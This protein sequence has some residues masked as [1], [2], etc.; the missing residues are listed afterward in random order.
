M[1]PFQLHDDL[2]LNTISCVS[3]RF[4][5]NL[6]FQFLYTL[7]VTEKEKADKLAASLPAT[8]TKVEI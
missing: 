4:N 5:S 7:K 3:N 2:L 6:L 1:Y 8:L